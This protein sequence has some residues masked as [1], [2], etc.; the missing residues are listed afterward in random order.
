MPHMDWVMNLS[1]LGYTNN[2]DSVIVSNPRFMVF[3][4]SLFNAIP[5]NDW[6]VYLKWN[7]MRDAAPYLS[8]SFV[9]ANFAFNKVLSGQKEQTPR[10]Q[11]M[12]TLIDGQLGELLGQL[13]V[14]KYFKPA[15]KERMLALVNNM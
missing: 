8:S 1:Q 12:S 5:V 6:R 14:D 9:D 15:A 2:T 13:H 4:D 7:V 10:W 11:R 3:E